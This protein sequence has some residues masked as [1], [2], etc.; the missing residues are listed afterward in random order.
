MPDFGSLYVSLSERDSQGPPK[1][2]RPAAGLVLIFNF[3]K[4]VKL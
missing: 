2:D 1:S 3:L 4:L